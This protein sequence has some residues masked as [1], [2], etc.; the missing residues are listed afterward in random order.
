MTFP[1]FFLEGAP[2]L[3]ETQGHTKGCV[4]TD[5]YQLTLN[6]DGWMRGI[7]E[8]GASAGSYTSQLIRKEERN[9]FLKVTGCLGRSLHGLERLN[10]RQKDLGPSSYH[11][12]RS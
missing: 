4:Q 3:S 1:K 5:V 10:C 12:A 6:Y 7:L 9:Y 11:W 2:V 8:E